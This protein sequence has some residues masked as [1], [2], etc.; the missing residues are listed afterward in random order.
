M[1]VDDW[2]AD[3]LESIITFNSFVSPSQ[4]LLSL[5]RCVNW[6]SKFDQMKQISGSVRYLVIQGGVGREERIFNLSNL[7]SLNTLKIG[8]SAFN[9]CYSVVFE[10]KNDEWMMN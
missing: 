3:T 9:N 10:G 8:C 2:D 7:S 5:N 6:V 4:H 1:I